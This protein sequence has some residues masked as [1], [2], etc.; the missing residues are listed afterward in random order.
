MRLIVCT[1][2]VF[3]TVLSARGQESKKYLKFKAKYNYTEGY[4]LKMD[5][6]KVEGVIKNR[7]NGNSQYSSVIFVSK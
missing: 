7:L 4:I 6:T 3:F 2:L 1:L 5:S